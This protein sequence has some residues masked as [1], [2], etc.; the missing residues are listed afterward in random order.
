[1]NQINTEE[2]KANHDIVDIVSKYVDIKKQGKDWFGCCPFRSEKSPS[3]SVNERDQYFHCFGCGANGDVIKFLMDITGSDFV[4]AAEMLGHQSAMNPMKAKANVIK[5]IQRKI[6][7][8]F[9]KQPV[10]I[11]EIKAFL[12]RCEVLSNPSNEKQSIYFYDKSQV[13]LMT[14]LHNN[15]ASLCLIKKVDKPRFMHKQFLFGTCVINGD[16]NGEV[17]LCENWFDAIKMHAVEGKNTVCY[18]D[19]HN[20]YFMQDELKRKQGVKIIVIAET[21]ESLYQADKFNL[22]D[23]YMG[24]IKVDLDLIY[25]GKELCMN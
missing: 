13:L 17:Y 16:L 19:P 2:I 22:L 12:G 21:E 18:F 23:C 10:D 5:H 24:G 14:D 15:P 25:E 8:P 3:F 9:D 20:L 7:L 11:S 6:R 1:M 4:E